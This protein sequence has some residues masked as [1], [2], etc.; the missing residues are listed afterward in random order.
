MVS[1]L[2]CSPLAESY[3]CIYSGR[4]LK[5]AV[6]K[7]R[8]MEE[9]FTVLFAT[10]PGCSDGR[11]GGDKK[12]K[13]LLYTFTMLNAYAWCNLDLENVSLFVLNVLQCV[14]T[15]TT[16]ERLGYISEYEIRTDQQTTQSQF[17]FH[18]CSY[19]ILE[20]VFSHNARRGIL[21]YV[22]CM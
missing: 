22:T 18:V 4:P 21:A 19:F 20:G 9:I 6:S 12:E 2:P 15:L 14:V 13:S 5:L 7:L 16:V 11:V 8:D 10:F 1:V 3:C 17:L